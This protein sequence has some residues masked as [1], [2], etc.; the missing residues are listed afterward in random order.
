MPGRTLGHMAAGALGLA[1]LAAPLAAQ[2]TRPL[3]QIV[4][5]GDAAQAFGHCAGFYEAILGRGSQ[6]EYGAETW[7]AIG[8]AYE[9]LIRA[10]A[11]A[12]VG[13]DGDV[14]MGLSAAYQISAAAS[15]AYV[16]RFE[17]NA[18]ARGE[19]IAGDATLESDLNICTA[20]RD[21][22]AEMGK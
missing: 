14:N 1:M 4:D 6:S 12:T 8:A 20:L 15:G 9:D 2:E 5:S 17:A 16:A 22:A 10:T 7:A 19:I 18:A 13:A 11:I 3:A 21:R